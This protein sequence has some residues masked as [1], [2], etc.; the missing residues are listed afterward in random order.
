MLGRH[1]RIVHRHSEKSSLRK[2]VLGFGP[3]DHRL[4][5]RQHPVHFEGIRNPNVGD[6]PFGKV[7]QPHGK[8][9]SLFLR[10]HGEK[11]LLSREEFFANLALFDLAAFSKPAGRSVVA[12][13]EGARKNGRRGITASQGDIG[14][15]LA[16]ITKK[17]SSLFQTKP[18]RK[19]VDGFAGNR[20]KDPVEMKRREAGYFSQ[21]LQFWLAIEILAKMVD[22]PINSL[23]VFAAGLDLFAWHDNV[24]Y[25]YHNWRTDVGRALLSRVS[26]FARA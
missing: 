7:D 12:R 9:R 23:G 3:F 22:D 11:I 13:A 24:S 10:P 25:Q 18:V 15:T 1:V 19:T 2:N 8:S 16:R 17:T 20:A 5:G 21:F 14:Q 4:Q 26:V 6:L